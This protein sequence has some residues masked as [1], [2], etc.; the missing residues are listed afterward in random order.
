MANYDLTQLQ[1]NQSTIL[2]W[3]SVANDASGQILV[4]GFVI[5]VLLVQ[6][7][8]MSRFGVSWVGAFTFSG[9]LCTIY[10]ALLVAAGGLLNFWFLL[11]F[12]LFSALGAMVLYLQ[13]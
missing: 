13:N 11:G 9:W 6:A 5:A 7:A 8:Y 3:V 1:S 4:A 12:G 10:V 2:T